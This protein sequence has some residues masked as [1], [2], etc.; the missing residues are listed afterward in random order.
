MSP[1]LDVMAQASPLIDPAQP[2]LAVT[3][4]LLGDVW[5]VVQHDSA[6]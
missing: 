1:A 6:P 2:L 5:V 3:N 4:Q